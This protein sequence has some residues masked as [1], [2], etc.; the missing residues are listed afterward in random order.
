MKAPLHTQPFRPF[1]FLAALDAAAGVAVWLLAP[2]GIEPADFVAAPLAIWHRDELLYGAA[3][4]ML[5]G[6]ILT[7]LPR[8]TRQKP[9]PLPFVYALAAVWLAARAAHWLAP[10]IAALPAGF[11]IGLVALILGYKAAAGRDRRNVKVVVLL[12]LLGAGALWSG[13]EPIAAAGEHGARL[14]LAA[15]MAILMV[16]GG[17]IV[18]SVTA[19]YL[20]RPAKA[21]SPKWDGRA[22]LFAGIAAVLALCAWVAAP[23][24]IITALACALAAAAHA[25]RLLHW[26]GWRT[27]RNSGVAVLHIGYAWIP[28]GFALAAAGPLDPGHAYDSAA[29][30]AWTAGAIGLCSLSVMS[31]TIRRYAGTAFRVPPLLS[32][33]Y[34]CALAAAITRLT[35][36][37]ADAPAPWLWLSA[38]AWATAFALFLI[39]FGRALLPGRPSAPFPPPPRRPRRVTALAMTKTGTTISSAQSRPDYLPEQLSMSLYAPRLILTCLGV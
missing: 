14:G 24:L 19:A 3:P 28:A 18:P 30:H 11:F 12:V 38:A 21:L 15:I 25:V 36:A 10:G 33:A 27:L 37:F 23:A 1:F 2:L 8:W 7:A 34:A 17:R 9:V 39:V 5:T 35:A 4:A 16:M 26:Q 29:I 20:G 31:S 22:E 13:G 32:T 6:V